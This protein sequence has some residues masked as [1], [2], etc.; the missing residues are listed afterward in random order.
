SQVGDLRHLPMLTLTQ[1]AGG[2]GARRVENGCKPLWDGGL[3][4]FGESVNGAGV[5]VERLETPASLG[6]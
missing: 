3:G 1:R 4:L 5:D 2:S 6:M